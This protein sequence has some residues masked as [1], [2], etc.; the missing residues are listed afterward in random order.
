MILQTAANVADSKNNIIATDDTVILVLLIH[1]V[2]KQRFGVWFQPN[3]KRTENRTWTRWDIKVAK[4]KQGNKDHIM[5]AHAILGCDTTSQIFG[6]G[7]KTAVEELNSDKH[8]L[9]NGKVFMEDTSTKESIVKSGESAIIALYKGTT[10]QTLN[11]LRLT[12]F[13]EK[14]I[15]STTLVQPKRLPPTSVAAKFHC[16]RVYQEVQMWKG[17]E[18]YVPP[19]KWGWTV[20]NNKVVLLW[21][22]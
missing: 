8:F 21:Q 3:P 12:K 2:G 20:S 10:D 5:F 11:D 7:K 13:L 17:N 1:H 9:Q 6:I 22:A 16:L 19:F 4:L 18:K 15:T 14:T